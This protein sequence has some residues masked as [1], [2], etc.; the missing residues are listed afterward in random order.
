MTEIR[1]FLN[2]AGYHRRLMEGFFSTLV[3][4]LTTLTKKDKKHKGTEKCE[5]SFLELTRKITTAPLLIVPDNKI[6]RSIII[7]RITDNIDS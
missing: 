5:E 3:V 1:S 2:F 4:P 6:Q 7:R